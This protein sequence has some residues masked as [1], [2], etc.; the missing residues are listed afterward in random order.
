MGWMTNPGSTTSLP[1]IIKSACAGSTR[2]LAGN[3]IGEK[4]RES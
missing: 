4:S 1:R 2:G 3:E